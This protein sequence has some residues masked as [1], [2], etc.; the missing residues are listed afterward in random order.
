MIESFVK[1]FKSDG[2]L[3]CRIWRWEFTCLEH[4]IRKSGSLS[5]SLSIF[6][7]CFS[8]FVNFLYVLGFHAVVLGFLAEF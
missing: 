8:V 6:L 1:D 2:M 4:S 3:F 7:L 5:L